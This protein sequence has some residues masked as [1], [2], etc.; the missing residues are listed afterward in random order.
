[1]LLNMYPITEHHIYDRLPILLFISCS[2]PFSVHSSCNRHRGM[3]KVTTLRQIKS[4]PL[5]QKSDTL[6]QNYVCITFKQSMSM[7]SVNFSWF[8]KEIK[9]TYANKYLRVSCCVVL[10]CVAC[11][12]LC[13]VCYVL[14][15]MC[16]Y[17]HSMSPTCACF[18]H[19]CCHL[20]GV[21]LQRT[22]VTDLNLAHKFYLHFLY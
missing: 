17:I 15:V 11:C 7:H 22:F 6:N 3:P 19:T 21:F 8:D 4:F 16:C 18:G 20:E 13:V 5:S 9:P 1:M 10:C 2:L 12:V 14:C